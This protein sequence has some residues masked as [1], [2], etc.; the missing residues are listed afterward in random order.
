MGEGLKCGNLFS[1]K[2]VFSQFQVS[3][4]SFLS[5]PAKA[6]IH[7]SEGKVFMEAV[8]QSCSLKAGKI[9]KKYPWSS[10]FS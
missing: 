4:N 5:A 3:G 8:V 10:F 1:P 7:Q 6:P 9:Y 2:P